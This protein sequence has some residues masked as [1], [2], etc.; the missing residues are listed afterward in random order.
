MAIKKSELYSS[1]W[2]SCDELRGGMDA[3]QYKDYVLILLF[4][5][6]ISD[7]YAGDPNALIDVPAGGGFTDMVA[8]KGDKEIGDRINKII[9]RLADANDSLKGA[10]NVADFN[11][12]EKLGKGKEMVDRLTKLVSIFEGLDFG[13]NRAEGDDL[14]G[15]AY[16][17]LMRHFATESGKSKGQFYTPA[18]VS[19]IMAMVIDLGKASNPDQSIYDPTCGSG[20]LLLKAHDEA[21]SRTGLDLALYGQEMDNATSALARMNMVLHDCPTAEVWQANTLSSPHFKNNDGSLKAFDFVVANFPFSVKSWTSGLDPVNDLYNRFEYGIPP[22]KNGDYAFLLHILASLKS[23]GKGAVIHPHGVLFRGGAEAVIRKRLIRQGYIKGIIGL[24]ANLFY[25]TGIPACILVLDK[26]G[27]AGRRGIFMLD[28]SKGFIK[29]GNKNRLRAQ[30]IHKIVDT[31]TRL[32][33]TPKYSRMVPLDEVEA[34]DFNLNL[35]RY[36]DSTTPEDLQDIEA[37]LKGGIP[38]RD[39]DGL[40]AYWQVFPN[41][42]C[43]LFADDARPGYCQPKVDA[44]KVKAAIFGHPEFSAF[45]NRV[46]QLFGVW[47]AANKPLLTGIKQGDRPKM[48]VDA[49]SETLLDTFRT[50]QEVA[51]LIDPYGVY[52]HLMDYWAVTMQDD[53]WM[54]A[55]DGWKATQD[56]KPN[57]DLISPALIVARYFSDEQTTIEQREAERDAI[58]RQMEE[59]DEEHGGEEG[60]LNEA[61]N[62]KGKLTK[63][64]VKARQAEIKRDKDAADERKLLDAYADL[65]EQEAAAGKAVKEAQKALDA[66]VAVKYKQLTEA[67]IKTLVV[68]DKWLCVLAASVQSELDRVSQALTGRIKQL[69]ERYA[70][71]L[72]KLA[73][74]VDTLAARVDEHLKKMGFVW[75]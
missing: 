42:R 18:E 49:L 50:A 71:P 38:K 47:K 2:K 23:T 31:F 63:A 54:I 55:S 43:E 44:S 11:D 41:V 30:D 21:K 67:E 6:Y 51:S 57:I 46:T 1:L 37:H 3:S 75:N 56:G 15:D 48:L 10:I 45:N 29:D 22:A 68:D 40:A 69:A 27:A 25:G 66:K 24:P 28:A 59:M 12:E 74:E 73:G 33:E 70:T 9:G 20:S 62:D 14:L 35:P 61:K 34:N 52:Q 53:A 64:S 7:K 65:I 26:E 32:L 8:A 13:G 60:L 5:K 19:R 39:I 4:I 72:P 58:S 36:I 16:E 17:Y